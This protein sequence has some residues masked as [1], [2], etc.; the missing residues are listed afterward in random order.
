MAYVLCLK[1]LHV[2]SLSGHS[3]LL[4]D[5]LVPQ[6]VPDETMPELMKLGCVPCD[7]HGNV[8]VTGVPLAV[9]RMENE[10]I[11]LY[12]DYARTKEREPPTVSEEMQIDAAVKAAFDAKD[13]SLIDVKHGF[14]KVYAVSERAGFKVT[15]L[16]IVASCKRLGYC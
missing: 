2:I 16:Q 9:R 5:K 8:I 12:H 1:P 11:P 7:E 15:R 6:P 4:E 3:L 10:D 13:T 14:P